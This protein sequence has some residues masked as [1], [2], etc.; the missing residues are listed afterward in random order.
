MEAESKIS[1]NT[2]IKPLNLNKTQIENKESTIASP[3][4]FLPLSQNPELTPLSDYPIDIYKDLQN[5]K[6]AYVGIENDIFRIF[7]S[8][9]RDSLS[10]KIYYLDEN[11]KI[12][13]LFNVNQH[14]VPEKCCSCCKCEIIN[15]GCCAY[16]Y[17][18]RIIYQLDY[19]KNNL[20]FATLGLNL[21]KGCYYC[22]LNCCDG[23]CNCCYCCGS[24][25]CS[26]VLQ[27]LFLRL[28][29]NPSNPDF[30]YGKFLGIS[31][32][33]MTAGCQPNSHKVEITDEN[34]VLKW[35]IGLIRKCC[36]CQCGCCN[37]CK[38]CEEVFSD[39]LFEIYDSDTKLCGDIIVP[40]G[41]CSYRLKKD[42]CCCK[43]C[44][45]GCCSCYRVTPY[46]EIHFPEK[47]NS[48]DKF[49]I[50]TAVMMFELNFRATN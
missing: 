1:N 45:G 23:C 43:S 4:P 15:C 5:I 30:S 41:S 6:V 12:N 49:Y 11:K 19:L 13:I 32:A 3:I 2:E 8:Q 18:N 36:D 37:C 24:C 14:F 25:K 39:K 38:C 27:K 31:T 9:E 10:F 35:T 48:L 46:Y 34:G 21:S 20:P 28:N 26:N 17:H 50:L 40:F 44:C 47:A 7:H 29:N 22:K 33:I 42:C 16:V